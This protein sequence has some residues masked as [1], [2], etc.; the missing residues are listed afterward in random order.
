[1]KPHLSPS[2]ISTFFKC[3]MQWYFRYVKGLKV[4]P[5]V[6]LLTGKAAHKG[7]EVNLRAKLE[8][9]AAL[10][11]GAALEAARDELVASWANEPPV[12]DSGLLPEAAM[13]DAI[14]TAV[15]LTELHHLKV[16]PLIQPT[17][18]ER[19]LRLELPGPYDLEM[20]IDVEEANG[21][22]DIKTKDGKSPSP[23]TA[24]KSTQLALYD[25]ARKVEGHPTHFVRLDFLV[26]RARGATYEA[27]AAQL[28]EDDHRRALDRVDIVARS[29]Q[30][31]IFPPAQPDSWACSA[32]WCGY[33]ENHCP[34]GRRQAVSA[35]V[36][37]AANG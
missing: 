33:W 14:D 21:V 12:V 28:T 5:G 20:Q 34:H 11:L 1:M 36:P 8:T 22:I 24:E 10:P 31:G 19:A 15:A 13:G 3:G 2:Q 7:A 32:K 4:P 29:I 9:G 6:A 23:G 26:R 27:Q 35:Q 37:L 25:L 30:A 16:A 18:V 17:A